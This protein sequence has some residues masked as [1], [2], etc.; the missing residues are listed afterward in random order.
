MLRQNGFCNGADKFAGLV[1][2]PIKVNFG[3]FNSIVRAIGPLPKI[4]FSLKSSIAG[5]KYSS[6]VRLMR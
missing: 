4:K 6:I 5:Y 2:A 1:V 3:N